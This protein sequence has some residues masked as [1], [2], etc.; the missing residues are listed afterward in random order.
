[1]GDGVV[2]HI[3]RGVAETLNHDLF[4]PW[5]FRPQAVRPRASPV[6]QPSQSVSELI[7]SLRGKRVEPLR[8]PYVFLHVGLPWIF[9]VRQVPLV[10]QS[11]HAVVSRSGHHRLLGLTVSQSLA[12]LDQLRPAQTLCVAHLLACELSHE[13]DTLIESLQINLSLGLCQ[14]LFVVLALD[15]LV[16]VQLH[17]RLPPVPGNLDDLHD[18]EG[19]HPLLLH[20]E[21]LSE[22]GLVLQVL[23]SCVVIRSV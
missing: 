12:S 19:H 16:L 17:C 3:D 2:R 22:G 18:L 23:Q 21:F 14:F 15:L 11:N 10:T 5:E 8:V 9:P 13:Q 7:Q 4:V 6:L 20:T 1:M